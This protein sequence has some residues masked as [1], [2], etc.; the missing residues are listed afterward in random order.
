MTLVEARD[1]SLTGPESLLAHERGLANSEWFQPVVDPTTMR[2]LQVRTNSRAARDVLLWLGLIVL[3]GVLAFMALGTWW[4]VPAFLAYGALIGGASDSR[5]HECGHGTAFKAGWANEIIY[6]FASFNLLRGPTVWRWSHYRHHTDTII[7]GRDAEIVFPRPPSV[8]RTAFVFTH[9]E[10][11]TKMFARLVRHAFGRI[12]DDVRDFVPAGEIR[13]VKWEAR[14]AVGITAAVAVWS[15]AIG[16]I[17]PLL[18]IGLPSIYGAWLVVFFG[19][20]QHA[21][22]REDV[23][24]HRLNSRTVLM[25]PIFRFLYLNMNYHV[26]HHIFP[27]VPYH[28]LPE[29]HAELRGQLAEPLP[30][31]WAAYREIWTTLA[32]QHNDPTYEIPLDIPVVE[33]A[34][35]K[36]IDVGERN[37]VHAP[38]DAFDFGAADALHVGELRRVDIDERTYVVCRLTDTEVAVA[39]GLCTH[40]NVHLCDGAIIDGAIECPKHNGRSDARTGSPV[41][42]P[43]REPLGVYDVAIVDGRIV[44]KLVRT[45]DHVMSHAESGES[46][47]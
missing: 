43:V 19:I 28:A 37:W 44:S 34:A 3:F 8:P 35:R 27:S 32:R 38:D 47:E 25:N 36:P 45:N 12:E 46:H 39:D 9:L 6:H 7:V 24:D 1:Y 26:E 2:S 42:R 18:F 10:G 14:V 15:V 13:R 22:M 40:Q 30:S 29:L 11:G 4:A 31:T 20:T 17:V 16:S 33:D 23:L 21:G 5:W 41:R